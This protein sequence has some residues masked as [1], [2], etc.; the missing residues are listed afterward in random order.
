MPLRLPIWYFS[1]LRFPTN[2]SP[3]LHILINNVSFDST[4]PISVPLCFAIDVYPFQFLSYNQWIE[5][6]L[7]YREKFE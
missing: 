4:V 7:T 1:R 2:P 3:P 5:I 6:F